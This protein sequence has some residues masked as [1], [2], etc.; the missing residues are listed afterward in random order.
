M[1]TLSLFVKCPNHLGV[2]FVTSHSITKA[3]CQWLLQLTLLNLSRH[4]CLYMLFY[5]ICIPMVIT[6]N[7]SIPGRSNIFTT[8][9]DCGLLWGAHCPVL[10]DFWTTLVFILKCPLNHSGTFASGCCNQLCSKA[11][12]QLPV[13]VATDSSQ[14]LRH[15]C[16]YLLLEYVGIPLVISSNHPIAERS[17]NISIAAFCGGTLSLLC[18]IFGLFILKHLLN[19]SGTFAWDCCN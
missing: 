1:G 6:S 16:Q 13:A 7:L 18:L 19:C 2:Y 8:A 11:Q 15:N 3:N 4:N 5:Y 14:L 10:F 12:T 17:N 9:W